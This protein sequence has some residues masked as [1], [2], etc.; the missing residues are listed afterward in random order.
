VSRRKP[1]CK[2]IFL[3]TFTCALDF[4]C[5]P[6]S[7][8]HFERLLSAK[9]SNAPEYLGA[10][11]LAVYLS[12]GADERCRRDMKR[13]MPSH[14]GD[15]LPEGLGVNDDGVPGERTI[16]HVFCSDAEQ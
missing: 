11:L 16:D 9:G 6:A 5:H 2:Q 10:E 1:S 15:L 12:A 3:F 4:W 13:I 8:L 7:Y 14:T